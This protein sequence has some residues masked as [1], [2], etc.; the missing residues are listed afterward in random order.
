MLVFYDWPFPHVYFAKNVAYLPF[1]ILGSVFSDG[2]VFYKDPYNH[3]RRLFVISCS[4]VIS[5][6]LHYYLRESTER[7]AT[8]SGI[9]LLLRLLGVTN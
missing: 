4:L 9:N 1:L 3:P 6:L 7:S 2:V 5:L 8:I